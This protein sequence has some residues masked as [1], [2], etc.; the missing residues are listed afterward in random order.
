MFGQCGAGIRDREAASSS[1]IGVPPSG[2]RG[3]GELQQGSGGI[4]LDVVEGASR[5]IEIGIEGRGRALVVAKE[6]GASAMV[7]RGSRCVC[8]RTDVFQLVER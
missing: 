7:M 8:G 5:E 4:N 3:A 2:R 1:P 6:L